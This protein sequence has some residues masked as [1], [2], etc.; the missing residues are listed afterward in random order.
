M[1]DYRPRPW[2]WISGHVRR[3]RRRRH[4]E[5]PKEWGKTWFYKVI[6]LVSAEQANLLGI[7][8]KEPVFASPMFFDT[9][10]G[11]CHICGRDYGP[12]V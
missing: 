7:A 5:Y 4:E 2:S 11:P 1:S 8:T 3:G 10:N 12:L 9:E 6:R